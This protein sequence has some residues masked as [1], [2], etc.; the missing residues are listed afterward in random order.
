MSKAARIPHHYTI[1]SSTVE[2]LLF[3]Y[4]S[5]KHCLMVYLIISI[6]TV[7]FQLR[8]KE[9]VI[10]LSRNSLDQGGTPNIYING[11]LF[12]SIK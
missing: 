7:L 1:R 9:D 11:T 3:D 12:V 6:V 10:A 4:C 8:S 2:Y 5:I